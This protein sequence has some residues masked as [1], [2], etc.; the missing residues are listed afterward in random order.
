MESV[1]YMKIVE[2]KYARLPLKLT[3]KIK[4]DIIKITIDVVILNF[5]LMVVFFK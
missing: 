4:K 5:I 1:K 2:N 3:I